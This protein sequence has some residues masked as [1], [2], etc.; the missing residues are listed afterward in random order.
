MNLT[1]PSRPVGGF[2]CRKTV[3]AFVVGT[4]AGTLSLWSIRDG[5]VIFCLYVVAIVTGWGCD[6]LAGR[7]IRTQATRG[8]GHD[9]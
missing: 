9:E 1:G 4:T 3:T 2:I 5:L 6:L 8:A 7:M